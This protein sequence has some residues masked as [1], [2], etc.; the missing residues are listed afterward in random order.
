MHTTSKKCV[1]YTKKTREKSEFDDIRVYPVINSQILQIPKEKSYFK[2]T[3]FSYKLR[4]WKKDTEMYNKKDCW[5]IWFFWIFWSVLTFLNFLDFLDFWISVP[6]ILHAQ[7]KC[8]ILWRMGMVRH[9]MSHFCGAWGWRATVIWLFV[10]LGGWC[11]RDS[12]ISVA[13]GAGAP[14]K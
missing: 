6:H 14:Q 7:Q 13:H 8:T 4:K 12:H 9:R 2:Q 10:A 11:T 3:I 1:L 5:I